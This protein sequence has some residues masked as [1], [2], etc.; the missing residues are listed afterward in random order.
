MHMNKRL[1]FFYGA[2]ALSLAF[3]VF[4]ITARN[5]TAPVS[6][7]AMVSKD[8]A[9]AAPMAVHDE[10]PAELSEREERM[11]VMPRE[12]DLEITEADRTTFLQS[13]IADKWMTDFG[14]TRSD[15]VRA[16]RKLREQ[17]APNIN[18]PGAIMRA[19][20]PRHIDTL[21]ITGLDVP[22]EAKAGHP[23]PF[24]LHGRP[25]SPSFTFARFDTLVQDD[26]IRIR[27]FGNSDGEPA[28]EPVDVIT[29]KGQIDPLP[30][31]DY[32]IEVLELGPNGSFK[33]AVRP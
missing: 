3:V 28:R 4:A 17:K 7:E 6:S 33:L 30:A 10:K 2:F 25:P 18:D 23:I 22:T 1:V 20:P 16:Q 24:T 12:E 31:G 15:I 21:S 26:I 9:K 19:L 14:Y 11:P 8:L 5:R 29:V 27:A 13:P 32:R